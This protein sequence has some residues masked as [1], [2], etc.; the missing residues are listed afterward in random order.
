MQPCLPKQ[1]TR[2]ARTLLVRSAYLWTCCPLIL[3][4]LLGCSNVPVTAKA[5]SLVYQQR[6]P[7]AQTLLTEHLQ[8]APGDIEARSLLIRVAARRS[9]VA[10][11]QTEVERLRAQLAAD[12]PRADLELGNAY[13]LLHR[14]D[15]ALE[16]YD[17]ASARA[18]TVPIGPKTGGM[19]A[20]RWGEAELAIPR[21][22]EAVKRGDRD[23]ET[24]HALGLA[25][26]HAGD[27]DAAT[28]SYR[29]GAALERDGTTNLTGL[30]TVAL[31]RNDHDA[32][33]GAYAAILVK[34]PRNAV[35]HL[36]RAYCLA[37]LDRK[38]EALAALTLA[39]QYGAPKAN[40]EKIR[41]LANGS[42]AP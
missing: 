36:G 25:L 30:A 27:L 13:E 4:L 42:T 9:D 17:H 29:A 40:V 11:V 10:T 18:P 8:R 22:Q 26:V 14:Y 28:L 35:A 19:R 7:E 41:T 34:T 2:F 15:E 39:E 3:S 23:P 16:A 1:R 31:A 21:L 6:D 32:A 37:R 20:A 24:Y 33:L 12:D 5:R 38:T